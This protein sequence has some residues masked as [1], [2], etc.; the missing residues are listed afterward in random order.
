MAGVP[1]APP[2]PTRAAP[3]VNQKRRTPWKAIAIALA[4]LL[5]AVLVAIALVATD[6]MKLGFSL[7]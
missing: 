1:L 5:A 3:V 4:L 7:L 2:N 6:V